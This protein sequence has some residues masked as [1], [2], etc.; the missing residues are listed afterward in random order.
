MIRKSPM[1]TKASESVA[2]RMARVAGTGN[3]ATLRTRVVQDKRHYSRKEKHKGQSIARA[4]DFA[5]YR[6]IRSIFN[7]WHAESKRNTKYPR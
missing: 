5:F 2:Q 6:A 7:I 3:G 1:K 4:M